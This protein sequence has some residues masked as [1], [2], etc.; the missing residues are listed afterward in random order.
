MVQK[1]GHKLDLHMAV[2]HAD[3]SMEHRPKEMGF[4][5]VN[6][7]YAIHLEWLDAV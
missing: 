4:H 7:P 5:V 6:D 3:F 1:R 2:M